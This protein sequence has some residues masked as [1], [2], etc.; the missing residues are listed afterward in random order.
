MPLNEKKFANFR[1][2]CLPMIENNHKQISSK[3]A[4]H[5]WGR[6]E[7][8]E[9]FHKENPGSITGSQLRNTLL[10]LYVVLVMDSDTQ[11]IIFLEQF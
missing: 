11:A 9:V 8:P 10:L 7:V 6:N 4:Q 1:A 5:K 3:G 2:Y